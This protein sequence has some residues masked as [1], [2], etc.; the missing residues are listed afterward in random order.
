MLAT[1]ECPISGAYAAEP[2]PMLWSVRKGKIG[3]RGHYLNSQ[4][5][6]KGS[7]LALVRTHCDRLDTLEREL[8]APP[9][10]RPTRV[11]RAGSE[12]DRP[13][14]AGRREW[15]RLAEQRPRTKE[16]R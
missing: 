13:E 8:V 15:I 4:I 7:V 2:P 16:A 9:G 3:G 5:E 10:D 14:L 6:L 12:V 11:R 1:G